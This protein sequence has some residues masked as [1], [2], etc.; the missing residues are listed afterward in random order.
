MNWEV[1]ES[2][3]TTSNDNNG[4]DKSKSS[5]TNS[6]SSQN[7]TIFDDEEVKTKLEKIE[8]WDFLALLDEIRTKISID[9]KANSDFIYK[10]PNV[11]DKLLNIGS[12]EMLRTLFIRTYEELFSELIKGF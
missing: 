7:K 11:P 5:K 2:K 8:E 6:K 10:V 1:G 12:E 9:N 3:P 4:K